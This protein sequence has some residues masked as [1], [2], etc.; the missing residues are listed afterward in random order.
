ML[1]C[2]IPISGQR[3]IADYLVCPVPPLRKLLISRA[4]NIAEIVDDLSTDPRYAQRDLNIG[5]RDVGKCPRSCLLTIKVLLAFLQLLGLVIQRDP[6]VQGHLFEILFR[7][8]AHSLR[9]RQAGY[10]TGGIFRLRRV[11][12]E[13]V[14]LCIEQRIVPV[15]QLIGYMPL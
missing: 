12:M 15:R 3:L 6:P 9:R 10:R 5:I 14:V 13:G 8:G 2:H 4:E 1:V 11:E 7:Q